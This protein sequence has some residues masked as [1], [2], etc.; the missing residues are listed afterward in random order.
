MRMCANERFYENH[1]VY[2]FYFQPTNL[3]LKDFCKLWLKDSG[4]TMKKNDIRSYIE[5]SS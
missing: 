4:D 2:C 1:D 5:T 3:L